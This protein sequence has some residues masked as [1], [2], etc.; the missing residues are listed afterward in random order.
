MI[1]KLVI[2]G[3]GLIGGSFAQA[4]RRSNMVRQI[5]GVGRNWENLSAALGTY[6]ID[7]AETDFASALKDADVV[8]LAVPVGQMA[9]VMEGMAPHLESHTVMTDVGST[10]QNVIASALRYLPHH[11]TR[12]V[13]AH[14]IA[15]AEQSGVKAATEDLFQ[16]KHVIVTPMQENST[17]AVDL[18]K[19][20]WQ[21]CGAVVHEMTPQSHDAIFAAVSHLPHVLA[22]A[23]VAELAARPNAAELFGFAAGGFRDFTRIASSH[24]EM[25]R[26]ICLANSAALLSELDAYS[27]QLQA[28]RAMIGNGDGAKLENIFAAARDARNRLVVPGKG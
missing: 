16:G 27:A 2:V 1:N 5:V 17:E 4:L 8:L 21:K 24:P 28:L 22:F 19:T 25:W 23:L 20:L 9:Y 15:G 10:K 14:P 13:P 7:S 6:V 11:L 26:D 12:F 18:V 3:V